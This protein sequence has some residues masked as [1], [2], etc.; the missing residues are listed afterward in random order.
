[1][2]LLDLYHGSNQRGRSGHVYPG[3]FSADELLHGLNLYKVARREGAMNHPPEHAEQLCAF[4]QKIIEEHREPHRACTGNYK[5]AYSDLQSVVSEAAAD[6]NADHFTSHI[7]GVER[8]CRDA[9]RNAADAV[10]ENW[11]RFETAQAE[12]SHFR[13]VNHLRN[14]PIR[15]QGRPL[16][17]AV[18]VALMVGEGVLNANFFS[19]A[20]PI[21]MIGGFAEAFM[22][23]FASVGLSTAAGI[24]RRFA[25][26]RRYGLR[27]IGAAALWVWA[28]LIASFHL[29]VGHYRDALVAGVAHPAQAAIASMQTRPLQ[30]DDFHSVI[31]V[32][33][34]LLMALIAYV[35]A[36]RLDDPIPGQGEAARGVAKAKQVH[37]DL[38]YHLFDQFK[39]HVE[40]GLDEVWNAYDEAR[41]TLAECETGLREAV[42]LLRDYEVVTGQIKASCIRLVRLYRDTNTAER[43]EKPPAYFAEDIVSP[44]GMDPDLARDLEQAQAMIGDIKTM[45]ALSALKA[46]AMDAERA[47]DAL[48]MKY[49]DETQA[50]FDRVEGK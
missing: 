6:W 10:V 23:S 33:V 2:G 27:R 40:A 30:L 46:R 31:L 41:D 4:E 9:L 8:A 29:M 37:T 19:S 43:S 24:C 18:L 11:K 45:E 25:N 22:I 7:T 1:M 36:Y 35:E 47:I 3:A 32:L 38:K 48:E 14:E 39:N 15:Y 17:V 50:V 20:S 5:R 12:L 44:F 28:P 49:R 42:D 13:E 21:G 26:A 16:K 34:G